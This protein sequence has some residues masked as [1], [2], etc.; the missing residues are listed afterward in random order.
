MEIK[1]R[2]ENN[3]G[4]ILLIGELDIASVELFKSGIENIRS[5]IENLII[6][7]NH[8]DFLDSTGVGSLVQIIR[9]LKDGGV[10]SKVVNISLDVFEVLDLLGIPEL[11]GEDLFETK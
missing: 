10:S 2:I 6:D 1:S 8:L 7:F 5:Q 11:L 9:K 3:T 4:V